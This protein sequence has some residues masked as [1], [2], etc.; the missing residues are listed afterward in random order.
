[1]AQKRSVLWSRDRTYSVVVRDASGMVLHRSKGIGDPSAS[2]LLGEQQARHPSLRVTL[3]LDEHEECAA[4]EGTGLLNEDYSCPKCEARGT[5]I[6][7]AIGQEIPPNG[8]I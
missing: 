3:H 4:C 2:R 6:I 8:V 5:V 1:M 7:D